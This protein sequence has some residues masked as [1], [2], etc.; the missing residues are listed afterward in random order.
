MANYQILKDSIMRVIKQNGNE[1]ITGDLLQQTL[2]AMVNII[3]D[4]Y[5]FKGLAQSSTPTPVDTNVFYIVNTPGEYTN[6]GPNMRVLPN[7]IA[8]FKYDGQWHKD[9]VLNDRFVDFSTA[10]VINNLKTF[11]VGLNAPFYAI[12][13]TEQ[14]IT[15][16]EALYAK[17]DEA[18][19]ASILA[20]IPSQATP[21][22]QLADKDYV[23]AS[24]S[25]NTANFIGTF[26]SLEELEEYPT[27]E[28]TNN[29]YAFVISTDSQGNVVYKRYKWVANSDAWLFEYDLNNSSFTAAQWA[30]INSGITQGNWDYV[31]NLV[32]QWVGII[33]NDATAQNPLVARQYLKDRHVILPLLTQ[34]ATQA[35]LQEVYNAIIGAPNDA[36]FFLTL[37]DNRGIMPLAVAKGG[38]TAFSQ[39]A[40][41]RFSHELKITLADNVYI[42]EKTDREFAT[43]DDLAIIVNGYYAGMRVGLADN[44]APK[45][46]VTEETIPETRRSGGSASIL[47]GDAVI[48]K[49][50]GNSIVW[51]QLF[52]KTNA[53]ESITSGGVTATKNE[54][55]SYSFS[56]TATESTWL[57]IFIGTIRIF[58]IGHKYFINTNVPI[59]TTFGRQ[60]TRSNPF[61][62]TATNVD[63]FFEVRFTQGT[64]T[65]GIK[66]RLQIV[67]LTQ[68]FGAGNEP[69]TYEDFLARKPKV[70]DEYAYDEG[71]IVH[72]TTTAILTKNEDESEESTRSL[73]II[74]EKFAE[75]FKG[76]GNAH[77]EIEIFAD[78]TIV[79]RRF[80]KV[81]LDGTENW[82]Y[83]VTP[84]AYF[85]LT[86]SDLKTG[87][88]AF[89][90]RG[91][92]DTDFFYKDKS[93]H[94]EDTNYTSVDSWKAHLAELY[95]AGTPLVVYYEL[96]EPI[97]EE[98]PPINAE[99]K[100]WGNGT[101]NNVAEGDSTPL[102]ADVVYGLD[103]YTTIKMNKSNIG[104]LASL[105]TAS[106]TD[107]VAAIN[108]LA[109]RL[110]SIEN[111]S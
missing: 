24:I 109:A 37:P 52:N 27:A 85:V 62:D 101:E 35:Q 84:K 47:D 53:V 4:G 95:A 104:N 14:G 97:V 48:K 32:Q 100:V 66:L 21:Q 79:R 10:Q 28:L 86:I 98:L 83:F 103:A 50:K 75:G 56:G 107:L 94:I 34:E 30:A 44:L 111:N 6:Y 96:A 69:S 74:T 39:Y 87:G 110:A 22:N 51:N 16:E 49:L 99:Y 46:E 105:T 61:I 70:A 9:L 23:N 71:T 68:M 5:N 64:S 82:T 1:E 38:T 8:I 17:A 42:L 102:I 15:L 65:D 54:D 20:L 58:I 11:A 78:K 40:D 12:T 60:E 18:I 41:G 45:G 13:D 36:A 55:G 43:S 92:V 31:L 25:S 26:D 19:V 76:F 29:D 59:F 57:N 72:N 73:P 89:D 3:G 33:P 80:N 93:L 91:K 108:E 88:K 77:D 90:V 67:D 2:I 106:K 7:E 63:S 81:V